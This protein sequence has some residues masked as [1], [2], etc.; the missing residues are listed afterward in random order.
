MT[1]LLAGLALFTLASEDLACIA[2]GVLVAR[3]ELGF[4]P[5]TL[6]CLLGIWV[7]DVALALA[8]RGAGR[9]WLRRRIRAD[10]WR[11]AELWFARRGD[12]AILVARFVPGMRLPTY[13]ASGLLAES[14]V[15]VSLLMLLGAVVW[16]PLLVGASA[17][18]PVPSPV[19]FV[20]GALALVVA[21]RLAT[22]RGRRALV[23][24]WRR[25]T[26]WEFWP[27]CLFYPPVIAWVAWLALKHRSL[28]VFTAANPAFP[29]GGLV[30]ESKRAILEG[31][32]ASGAPIAAFRTAD[33]AEF[34]VVV[35]PDVGERGEGVVI[36]RDREA[37]DRALREATRDVLIQEYVEG[38]ELGV[39][40]A[41]DRV[42]SITE[43]RL[44][45][46]TGDGRRSIEA[47][48][49]DD[50][51]AVAMAGIYLERLAD[52]LEEIPPDGERVPLATIGNHCRGAI[53]LDGA[54]FATPELIAAIDAIARGVRGF[55]F[56]RFD[57]RAPTEADLL[58]G[59]NLKILE[60]NGV[61][62]ES[63]HIYDPRHGV[64]R[65]WRTLFAQWR[66][67]FEIGRANVE[68]G[69]RPATTRDVL[70]LVAAWSG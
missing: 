54:R 27:R 33:T 11:R 39:F 69:S 26:R 62:S 29:A 34:P 53:F 24:F 57:L 18:L 49:L 67:A 3:G 41:D 28:W 63:T 47:L 68:R 23:G 31:L 50:P 42:I 38:P 9:A 65:A 5:A 44:P 14:L 40:W 4:F 12:A 7:G 59:R 15:R 36:A 16:V 30:G 2:A 20:L 22:W 37:L 25:W 10:A 45:F 13:V 52:R 70:R 17:S 61:L 64:V 21:T 1:A 35:K 60:L 66:L 48:V 46:V 58:A 56:G 6:A 32:A 55:H 8:G 43:K 19:A 51:R